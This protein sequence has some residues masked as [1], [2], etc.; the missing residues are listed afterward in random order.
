MKEE[1]KKSILFW[2]NMSKW[3][4]FIFREVENHI[5]I[6]NWS[7]LLNILNFKH[8]TT[9][10]FYYNILLICSQGFQNYLFFTKFINFLLDICGNVWYIEDAERKNLKNF[11]KERTDTRWKGKLNLRWTEEY[12]GKVWVQ[13]TGKFSTDRPDR[14]K[15]GKTK[16]IIFVRFIY[17][18]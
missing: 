7:D 3:F 14:Y 4:K 17:K 12:R 8:F 18:Y 10:I 1:K 9:S 6:I 16:K 2:K 11:G 13:R 15:S 5:F